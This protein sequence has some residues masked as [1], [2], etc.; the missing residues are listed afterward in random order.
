MRSFAIS[1]GLFLSIICSAPVSGQDFR[2]DTEV[3]IGAEKKP[4]VEMLTIFSGGR[5]YDF[6]L[7]SPAEITI[8]EPARANITLLDVEQKLRTDLKTT[9]LLDA[10]VE[11]QAAAMQSDDAIFKAAAKPGYEPRSEDFAENGNQYIRLLFEGRPIQYTVVA[12]KPRHAEAATHYKYFADWSAR[13]SSVRPP[14]FPAGARLEL[15]EALGKQG[16]IPIRVEKVIQG[17]ILNR[18]VEVRSEHLV[19]WILSSEDRRRIDKAGDQLA[20]S[21]P[22]EFKEYCRLTSP[23]PQQQAQR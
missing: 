15:N 6:R 17:G 2:I 16:L 21:K 13:L 10:A 3:F 1:L 9:H 22:V 14:N 23:K 20:N 19:N 4:E 18:K 11:L 12:Q 5:I 8:Y 7:T